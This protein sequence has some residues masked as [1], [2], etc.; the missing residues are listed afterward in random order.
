VSDPQG[1]NGHGE[2]HDARTELPSEQVDHGFS[3]RAER[4]GRAVDAD[5]AAVKRRR[6]AAP[7]KR[8]RP[9]MNELTRGDFALYAVLIV[10]TMIVLDWAE[11]IRTRIARVPRDGHDQVD[12]SSANASPARKAA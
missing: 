12:A 6:V 1:R 7:P 11:S 3:Y 9:V 10:V 4:L 5:A 8:G 2:H